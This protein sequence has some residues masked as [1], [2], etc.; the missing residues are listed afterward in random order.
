MLFV[1]FFVY[2]IREVIQ[3]MII[4]FPQIVSKEILCAYGEKSETNRVKFTT[5]PS[6]GLS[7][8]EP[9]ITSTWS[10]DASP[11]S[12]PKHRRS[13]TSASVRDNFVIVI[14]LLFLVASLYKRISI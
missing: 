7:G 2:G 3:R 6:S 4:I 14:T 12:I 9:L 10:A 5:S 8:K 13:N 1:D 11:K